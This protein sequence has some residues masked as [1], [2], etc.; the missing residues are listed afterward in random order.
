MLTFGKEI[1]LVGGKHAEKE[2]DKSI[3]VFNSGN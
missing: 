3:F 1:F 2:L